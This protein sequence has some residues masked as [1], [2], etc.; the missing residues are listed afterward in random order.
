MPIDQINIRNEEID[1]ILGKTPNKIIRWG[2]TVIFLIIIVLLTGSWFFK[3]PD[4][5]TSTIEITTLSPPA[6]IV[7]KA[8]GKI[9]SIYVQN[10]ELVKINT[11]LAIIENPADYS[12][13]QLLNIW[14]GSLGPSFINNDSIHVSGFF[15]QKEMELGELQANSSIFISAYFNLSNFLQQGYYDKK[16]EAIEEE[17]SN[18]HLYYDYTYDQKQTKMSDLNLAEK[19]YDRHQALFDSQTIPVAELEKSQSRYLIK[20]SS[21]ESIRTSLAN[22]NI[23]ISRLEGNVLDL[24]LQ[25]QQKKENL[26]ISLNEAYDNLN[27]QLDMWEQRYVLK[28]PASGLCIFTKYWSKNQNITQGEKLMTIIPHKTENIIGKLLLP[29][30]GAG[31][32]KKGQTVNIRLHNYPYMEFGMLVGVVHSISSIPSEGFYYVEVNIPN[33]M[34]T[35]YG[36]EIAFSQKMSG[37]AEIITGDIRLLHRVLKPIKSILTDRVKH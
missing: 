33:G 37:S 17:I 31:K 20:K 24:K 13:V 14:L 12:D 32:V 22:I 1:E 28:A 5:I 23:Q 9:D 36:I 30:R 6:D 10:N 19:D 21:F 25:D 35:S 4:F 29:V 18:H 16:I 2:V 3:Y 11:V 7:A 26:L 15:L 34:K 8:T 27:A